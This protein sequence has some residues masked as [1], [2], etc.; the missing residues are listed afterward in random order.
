MQRGQGPEGY[1]KARPACPLDRCMRGSL[2]RQRGHHVDPLPRRGTTAAAHHRWFGARVYSRVRVLSWRLRCSWD[3][4]PAS[5]RLQRNAAGPAIRASGPS[6]SP[7][8]S[9]MPE[10][11]DCPRSPT[12]TAQRSEAPNMRMYPREFPPGRRKDPKRRTEQR[13]HAAPAGSDRRGFCDYERGLQTGEGARPVRSWPLDEARPVMVDG[14]D[15]QELAAIR[16][17]S[18]VALA[19]G[20]PAEMKSSGLSGYRIGKS[21]DPTIRRWS[22]SMR[23]PHVVRPPWL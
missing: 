13:V 16:R 20:R 19:A 2:Q 18:D 12:E 10:E 6:D 23:L 22:S 1:P 5:G 8:A 21:R 3:P 11:G 15:D 14:Q 7:A 17:A 9:I 4:C